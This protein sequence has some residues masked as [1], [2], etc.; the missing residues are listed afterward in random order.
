MTEPSQLPADGAP[1]ETRLVSAVALSDDEL[2]QLGAELGAKPFQVRQIRHWIF[3]R[4]AKSWDECHNLP[5]VLREQLKARLPVRQST[6]ET[7]DDSDDGT[8]K[9]LLRL[10]DDESVETVIIPEGDR[11]TLCVSSQVGCP[12]ACIFCASG[13]DGVR[14]NL[15]RGEILEQFLHARDLLAEADLGQ[16]KARFSNVV[17]MGLGEPMLNLRELNPALSRLTDPDGIGLGARRVTVS[18]SGHP[19]RMRE[20][21]GTDR[22]YGLAVSLH[23]ADDGLRKKLVPTAKASVQEIVDA[24]QSYGAKHNREVTFEVVLLDGINDDSRAADA[25]IERLRDLRCTVNLI[26]WNPV[27]RIEDLARPRDDRVDAFAERLRHGRVNVTV[28]RQR[29]A[30]RSA[31]CGQLR[32]RSL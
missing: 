32:L 17:V 23:A 8:R 6:I 1:P 14:R 30:D 3:E 15:R 20:F 22:H 27:D 16:T 12:V 5:K 10:G 31:A 7:I 4:G 24:A 26:P 18:T 2:E 29:G 19:V 25:L 11:L 28:R 9:L 21:A 13:L